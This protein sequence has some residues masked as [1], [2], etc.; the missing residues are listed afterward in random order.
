MLGGPMRLV[1]G[2]L[3]ATLCISSG[4]ATDK[5]AWLS[6]LAGVP[7]QIF[8]LQAPDISGQFRAFLA[9][10]PM[11][12]DRPVPAPLIDD[13]VASLGFIKSAT[14]ATEPSYFVASYIH[15][16][17]L[18]AIPESSRERYLKR[19][20]EFV[21]P[22]QICPVFLD[23]ADATVPTLLS[24]AVNLPSRYF[25]DVQGS[26]ENFDRLFGLTEASHCGFIARELVEPTVIPRGISRRDLRTMLEALGDFE[27]IA[28]FRGMEYRP[29]R[30]DEADVLFASRLLATFLLERENPYTPIPALLHEYQRIG[31]HAAHRR[32][33]RIQQSVGAARR[34]VQAALQQANASDPVSLADLEAT[35]RHAE[36]M[37]ELA[38]DD[39]LARTLIADLQPAVRLLRGDQSAITV[40]RRQTLEVDF[41]DVR[42]PLITLS[43]AGTLLN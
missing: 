27:A 16:T 42:Q 39:A 15:K 41:A 32:M 18:V 8:E 34:V 12:N 19:Y 40:P 13:T 36:A 37:G 28:V 5:T 26:A 25:I 29:E 38:V 2:L 21:Y 30:A 17:P 31:I 9:E 43:G 23:S 1:I 14:P 22:Q 3:L 33:G 4:R 11:T 20:G 10:V 35:L 24:T 6:A 7:I